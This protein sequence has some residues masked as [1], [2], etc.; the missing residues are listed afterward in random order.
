M[1][2]TLENTA[3]AA[4]GSSTGEASHTTDTFW[5]GAVGDL[6]RVRSGFC[7]RDVNPSATPGTRSDEASGLAQVDHATHEM[8]HLQERLFARSWSGSR[9][10]VLVILQAMDAAGKGGLVNHVFGGLEPYGLELTAFKAPTAEE[11]AHDFL[12]RIEP[13]VPAPGSIGLFDRSHY[14]DVLVQRVHQLAPPEEIERRYG[15]INDFERRITDDGVRVVKVMLHISPDEQYRRLSARLDNPHKFWKY[16]PSDTNE[17][18]LWSEYMEAFQI[19]IDRTNT[20]HAPWHVVP[21]NSKWYARVAVQ[22]IVLNE[23]E[24]LD[25]DWPAAEYDVSNE[26]AR[27]N[28]TRDLRWP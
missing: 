26:I 20:S 7:L 6:L 22:R 8:R 13:H 3:V 19:A 27:L 17:R 5:E 21:A 23:L 2:H 9:D 10:R 11:K 16:S 12:W 18:A 4:A 25:L 24:K 1:T 14:E 15:A 28:A